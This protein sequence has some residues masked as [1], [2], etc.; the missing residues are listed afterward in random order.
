MSEYMLCVDIKT[1]VVT[2]N[3]KNEGK[4]GRFSEEYSKC[5]RFYKTT[6][7]RLTLLETYGQ[8]WEIGMY[9]LGCNAKYILSW[10]YCKERLFF[11]VPLIADIRNWLYL[12]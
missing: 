11:V 2:C 3:D 7:M 8:Y 4:C 5:G 12:L 1:N 9:G 10:S 6:E